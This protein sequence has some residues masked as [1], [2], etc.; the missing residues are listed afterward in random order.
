MGSRTRTGVGRTG[1][2]CSTMNSLRY[3][4]AAP[5]PR[6]ERKYPVRGAGHQYRRPRLHTINSSRSAKLSLNVWL[7]ASSASM[8]G[9]RLRSLRREAPRAGAG[10][11]GTVAAGTPTS[12]SA[13]GAPQSSARW[14]T[15]AA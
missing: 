14:S 4:Y 6:G 8:Y 13:R 3:F 11:C 9:L 2:A 1:E 5:T 12:S 7:A 15:R 10:S